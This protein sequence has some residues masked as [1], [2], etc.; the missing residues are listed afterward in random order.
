M[1]FV[2]P[3]LSAALLMTL[4]ACTST[5]TS[6]PP[7]PSSSSNEYQNTW[8]PPSSPERPEV[9]HGDAYKEQMLD[10]YDIDE[11]R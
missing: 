8:T 4:A 6:G 1:K 5:D 9:E 10:R 11:D 7:R 3:L 2:L